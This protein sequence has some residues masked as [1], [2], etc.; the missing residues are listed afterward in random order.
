MF[1]LRIASHPI[2]PPQAR[3]AE[4]GSGPLE[5]DAVCTTEPGR[6]LRAYEPCGRRILRLS[7]PAPVESSFRAAIE[8]SP[9]GG[10]RALLE[11][12]PAQLEPAAII[13]QRKKRTAADSRPIWPPKAALSYKADFIDRR[14]RFSS[15]PFSSGLS[16]GR[17]SIKRQLSRC[18]PFGFESVIPCVLTKRNVS[19]QPSYAFDISGRL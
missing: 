8:P 12:R 3:T 6:S 16:S 9:K 7:N 13:G 14:W 11:G 1:S 17:V 5:I 15:L 18:S 10:Y 4:G 2:F 19:L